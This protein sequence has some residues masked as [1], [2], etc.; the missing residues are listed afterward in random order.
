M[1]IFWLQ[2]LCSGVAREIQNFRGALKPECEDKQ[3]LWGHSVF[4]TSFCRV[5]PISVIYFFF[6]NLKKSEPNCDLVALWTRSRILNIRRF[7]TDIPPSLYMKYPI[8][9]SVKDLDQ[10][11]GGWQRR[12]IFLHKKFLVYNIHLALCK[13][14]RF[15]SICKLL[16][17]REPS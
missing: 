17:H 3:S 8:G 1:I 10:R 14:R 4:R 13:V 11:C 9:S 16:C 5:G 7:S 2:K 15:F 12:R 6:R